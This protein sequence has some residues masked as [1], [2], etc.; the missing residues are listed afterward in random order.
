MTDFWECL[1]CGHVTWI[2]GHPPACCPQCQGILT[3]LAVSEVL[4]RLRGKGGPGAEEPDTPCTCYVHR[5]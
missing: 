2:P 3:R 1:A 4:Q 5:W